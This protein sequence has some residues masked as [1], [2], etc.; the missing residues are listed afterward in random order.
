[1]PAFDRDAALKSAEKALRQ[2]RIDAAIAEYVRVV[3]AQPRDWNSA[4]ALG[5]LYAR[6]GQVDKGVQYYTRIADHL[7]GEGFLPKAAALYKKILRFKPDDEYAL[8][9]SGEIAA[10]Q[11]LLADARQALKAVADRRRKRGDQKGAAQIVIRLGAIDPEDLEAR[12][13]GARAAIEIGDSATA[14]GEYRSVALEFDRKGNAAA[15]LA[16]FQSAFDLDSSDADVRGRL[17][18]GYLTA[19]E[20]ARA[21]AVAGG[22]ADLK[23]VVAALDSTDQI[24]EKLD[25][26]AQV[27][28]MDPADLAVRAELARS[29]VAKGD[30][31]RAG[32]YLDAETAGQDAGLWLLLAEI[33]LGGGRSDTGRSAVAQALRLDAGHARAAVALGC[34][35][36]ERSPEDGY[37]CLDAVADAALARK[38]FSGAAAALQELVSRVPQHVVA[39]M[40]LVE[41]CVDGSL[42]STMLEAQAQLAEAYLGVGRGLEARII[43]ED[44]LSREPRNAAHVDRFRRALVMLGEADPEAIIADRVSGDSPFLA[45]DELDLNE[46]V[47]FEDEPASDSAGAHTAEPEVQATAPHEP[48]AAEGPASSP[49]RK[50]G[51]APRSAE[52]ALHHMHAEAAADAAS[53]SDEAA[54]EQLALAQTYRE[55]GMVDDALQA[56]ELAAQSPRHR[57]DAASLRGALHLERDEIELAVTWYERAAEAPAPTPAAG[58]ALLYDLAG[59]LE[60]AG[61]RSRALAVLMEIEAESGGYRDVPRRIEVLSKVKAKG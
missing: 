45:T 42:E 17:L 47:F 41:I 22:P 21:R 55:L 19:G 8:L 50:S 52:D 28:A 37:A 57:F 23:R 48:A 34:R 14:L 24:D 15:S 33:E 61:E 12:L 20:L 44:L 1:M 49:K 53:A 9:Q 31:E 26:L 27:A 56:L 10:R 18:D 2:G 54:A 32:T 16:A 13:N 51:K 4:N 58:R 60:K 40:R 7:A 59:T 30:L 29:H 5:D 38:D 46:G 3:E 39:L 6:A 43:S 36:A 35:L 11:G 25:V